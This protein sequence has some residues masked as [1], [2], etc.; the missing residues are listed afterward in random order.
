[1]ISPGAS[2]GRLR[3][4]VRPATAAGMPRLR[5][6][7][8]SCGGE[9]G[10]FFRVQDWTC[11]ARI[12]EFVVNYPLMRVTSTVSCLIAMY[13]EQNH[14]RRRRRFARTLESTR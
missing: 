13:E 2:S 9:R 10:R 3:V 6:T 4:P 14:S 11:G 1:M 8:G 7:A 5:Q 12:R